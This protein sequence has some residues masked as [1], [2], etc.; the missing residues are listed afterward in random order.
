MPGRG[1]C[2][3]FQRLH[4]LIHDAVERQHRAGGVLHRAH[5]AHDVVG[6]E[7][8]RADDAVDPLVADDLGIFGAVDLG[9][10]LGDVQVVGEH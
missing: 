5:I 9:D 7:Q 8:L 1:A 2:E 10:H 3:E 4:P 6:A